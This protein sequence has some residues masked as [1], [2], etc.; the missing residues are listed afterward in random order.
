[1]ASNPTHAHVPPPVNEPLKTYAPGTPERAA[2]KAKIAEQ[3]GQRIQIPLI[4]DGKI[5][6][7]AGVLYLLDAGDFYFATLPE[8]DPAWFKPLGDG[9]SIWS[10]IPDY[11]AW[12]A[13][14][15]CH[16]NLVCRRPNRQGKLTGITEG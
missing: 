13:Y 12:D 10:H 16:R 6:N 4:I 3:S 5:A 9:G 15:R 7:D 1:M 8:G 14:Y 11:G 2:L